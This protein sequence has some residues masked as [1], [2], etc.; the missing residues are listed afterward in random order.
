MS[1]YCMGEMI[2]RTRKSMNMSQEE[3]AFGICSVSTLSRIENGLETPARATFEK[4][5]ERLGESKGLSPCD[6]IGRARV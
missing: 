2:K 3:L 6:K 4:M 1:E 5:V